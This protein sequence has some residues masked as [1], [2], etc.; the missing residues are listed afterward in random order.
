MCAESPNPRDPRRYVVL[1]EL[2][3]S[4]AGDLGHW[5]AW[6]NE[7]CA[8]WPAA[9]AAKYTGPWNRRTAHPVLVVN[10]TYDPA[11]PYQGG[12]AMARE[13]SH[14]RLLTLKGYGHTALDNPSSCVNNHAVRYFRDGRLPPIGTTCEQDTAPF[15]PT[16]TLRS[17]PALR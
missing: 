5:W 8:T 2:S 7:P 13:L 11:T 4:R 1:D 16:P 3:T 9:A 6:A 14:A 10:P 17:G 15:A 12:Q